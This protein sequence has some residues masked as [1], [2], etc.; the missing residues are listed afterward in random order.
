MMM[1]TTTLMALAGLSMAAA[2]AKEPQSGDQTQAVAASPNQAANQSANL[3]AAQPLDSDDMRFITKAA[4]GGMLETELGARAAELGTSD[5]V[6]MFGQRMQ[7]DHG[8]AS[9]ELQ[10]VAR[11]KGV[12]LPTQLDSSDM[13]KLDDL[14]KRRGTDFD[15]H[16]AKTM[17]DDHQDD[18]SDF[19]KASRDLKDPELRAWAAR[20]LPTLRMHLRMAEDMKAKVSK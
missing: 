19:E 11:R 12:M 14:T 4:Q 13:K 5:D 15:E 1:K 10:D 3:P 18:V 16:Y 9:A 8:Q 6:K 2:C 20:T 7:T 17:V